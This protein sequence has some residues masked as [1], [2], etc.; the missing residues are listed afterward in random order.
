MDKGDHVI[1]LYQCGYT[2]AA[3]FGLEDPLDVSFWVAPSLSRGI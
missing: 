2:A 1:T 3:D